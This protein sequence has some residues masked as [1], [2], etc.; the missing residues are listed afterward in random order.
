MLAHWQRKL[1]D[2][3]WRH[4]KISMARKKTSPLNNGCNKVLPSHE[5]PLLQPPHEKKPPM[6]PSLLKWDQQWWHQ[7]M[8]ECHQPTKQCWPTNEKLKK[9]QWKNMSL[10]LQN[11]KPCIFC[12]GCKSIS[13]NIMGCSSLPTMGSME[14]VDFHGVY[15]LV[16]NVMC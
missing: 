5:L 15:W 2:R 9:R 4:P 8:C 13:Y 1:S 11:L 12:N 7:P 6:I 16:T 14:E 10:F 3:W